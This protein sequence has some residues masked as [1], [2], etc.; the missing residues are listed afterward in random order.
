MDNRML[1]D[2]Y[3]VIQ[4]SSTGTIY[5]KVSLSSALDT[6]ASQEIEIFYKGSLVLKELVTLVNNGTWKSSFINYLEAVNL[7]IY[8]LGGHFLNS[9]HCPPSMLDD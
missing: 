3:N 5:V 6:M 4:N 7:Y 2:V 8:Y 9:S 1:S